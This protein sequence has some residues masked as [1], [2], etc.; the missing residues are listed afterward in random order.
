MVR[1][2]IALCLMVRSLSFAQPTGVVQDDKKA[3]LQERYWTMKS[4]A[5]TYEDYKVIKGYVLDGV[6][7]MAMDS[8][9]QQRRSVVEGK[10]NIS[11]LEADLQA[12]QLTM[13][14]EREAVAQFVYD[15][16]HISV[17]GIPF[18]KSLFLLLMA[19][20]VTLLFFTVSGLMTKM[21]LLQTAAKEKTVIAD[22]TTQ[23]F[24]EFKK[25]AMEKQIK[26]ARELQNER[27]K[28]ADLKQN[29][30]H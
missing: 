19:G 20:V 26:L 22:L 14:K 5:E 4:K 2:S 6:W 28:L 13:T 11:K 1:L 9:K 24:E 3:T 15:S 25:K 29:L 17:L 12:L 16:T 18:K 10:Q 8:M 23:E 27:N 7:K 21:K 30:A